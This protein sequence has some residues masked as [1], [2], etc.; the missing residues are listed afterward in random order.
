MKKNYGV[1]RMEDS[2]HEKSNE[3]MNKELQDWIKETRELPQEQTDSSEEK[4]KPEGKCEICGEH[5]ATKICLKCEKSVCLSCFFKIIGICKRCVPAEISA[6]W[7]GKTPDWEQ[8][9]GVQWV[10]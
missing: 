3:C 8:I 9:L 7:E 10:G 5:P 2:I 4:K 6:K 1:F